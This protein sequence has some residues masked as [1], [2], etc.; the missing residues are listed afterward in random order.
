MAPD[1]LLLR[2]ADLLDP[3][4]TPEVRS[5]RAVIRRTV[6]HFHTCSTCVP[7]PGLLA[8]LTALLGV[9]GDV[10]LDA[11][12]VEIAVELDH[13]LTTDQVPPSTVALTCG[14]ATPCSTFEPSPVIQEGSR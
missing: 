9:V 12:A 14:D 4:C 1:P 3:P 7:N 11:A 2:V 8:D 10:D 6:E 5:A 13:R